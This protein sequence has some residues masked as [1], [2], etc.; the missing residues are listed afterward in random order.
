MFNLPNSNQLG[1]VDEGK[2]NFPTSSSPK[3]EGVGEL[4]FSESFPA[5]SKP[6]LLDIIRFGQKRQAKIKLV[7]DLYSKS[8][9]LRFYWLDYQLVP[10]WLEEKKEELGYETE[11]Y[12]MRKIG[13]FNFIS[14]NDYRRKRSFKKD[15]ITGPCKLKDLVYGLS[16]F[17]VL[18]ITID[19]IVSESMAVNPVNPVASVFTGLFSPDKLADSFPSVQEKTFSPTISYVL[20]EKAEKKGFYRNLMDFLFF[21]YEYEIPKKFLRVFLHLEDLLYDLYEFNISKF[22]YF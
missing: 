7:A 12:W 11:E 1:K 22:L 16:A 14:S 21:Y 2:F 5:S 17:D 10:W 20:E 13:Y 9:L 18:A 15:I 6:F 8:A 19:T 4:N 3:G